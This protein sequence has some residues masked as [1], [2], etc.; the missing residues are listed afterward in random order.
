MAMFY[1][2]FSCSVN[3][4]QGIF[5]DFF[6]QSFLNGSETDFVVQQVKT[7]TS[8]NIFKIYFNGYN[9]DCIKLRP[10]TYEECVKRKWYGTCAR[11]RTVHTQRAYFYDLHEELNMEKK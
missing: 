8:T 2:D 9:P 5:Y 7:S 1:D 10:Y 4:F 3:N 11:H 6:T